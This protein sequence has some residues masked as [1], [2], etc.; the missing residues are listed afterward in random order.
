MRIS[1]NPYLYLC[2]FFPQHCFASGMVDL[3]LDLEDGLCLW[4]EM[5]A[6]VKKILPEG[7]QQG[8]L[9]G[10]YGSSNSMRASQSGAVFWPMQ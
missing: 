1:D 8:C 9:P 3:A 4:E 10:N 7:T 6:Q 2:G 5:H